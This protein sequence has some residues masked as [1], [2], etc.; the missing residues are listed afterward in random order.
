M[1]EISQVKVDIPPCPSCLQREFHLVFVSGCRIFSAARDYAVPETEHQ[2]LEMPSSLVSPVFLHC[3]PSI[4]HS[5]SPFSFSSVV[6]F[7][8]VRTCFVPGPIANP[9]EINSTP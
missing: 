9:A 4:Y 8:T 7:V 6:R 1:S 3:S 5:D 2:G